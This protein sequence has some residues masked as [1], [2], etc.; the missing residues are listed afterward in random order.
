MKFPVFLLCLVFGGFA[1]EA[2]H[3]LSILGGRVVL[4]YKL[5]YLLST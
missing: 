4:N 1:I 3:E 5:K 2:C